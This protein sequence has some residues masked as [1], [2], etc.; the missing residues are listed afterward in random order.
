M[1]RGLAKSR[2]ITETLT[3]VMTIPFFVSKAYLHMKQ[4]QLLNDPVKLTRFQLS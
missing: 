1:V 4:Y 2:E 3:R